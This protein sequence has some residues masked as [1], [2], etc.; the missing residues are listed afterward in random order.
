MIKVMNNFWQDFTK[1]ITNLGKKQKL[2]IIIVILILLLSLIFFLSGREKAREE[3]RVFPP[4]LKVSPTPIPVKPM[5]KEILD[6]IESQRLNDG[7]YNYLAHYEEQCKIKEKEMVCPFD[8]EWTFPQT[9]AWTSLAYLAGYRTLGD[10]KYLDPAK[11]DM[12]RLILHCENK[13]NDCLWT[14]VQA[15]KLYQET[16]EIHYL[17]FLKKEGELLLTKSDPNPLLLDIETR[18]LAILFGVTGDNRYLDE[19]KKR[20]KLSEESFSQ[21]EILYQS[22][23]FIFPQK[24]CWQTLAKLELAR[25]TKDKTYLEQVK[26]FLDKANIIANFDQFPHPIEIQPCLETYFE[27]TKTSGEEQSYQEGKE[28]LEKFIETFWDGNTT[29]LIYG[30]GGTIFNPYPERLTYAQKYVVLTDS[31]YLAYLLGRCQ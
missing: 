3:R 8:G 4:V 18:Q 19:A 20:L 29:R 1:K 25:Q 26:N 15:A 27:L 10:P 6:Y 17:D 13:P 5:V 14:L 11:R 23:E 7:F 12:D 31:A 16:G 24:A 2:I 21:R 30:E 28:L 9:N 22:Q